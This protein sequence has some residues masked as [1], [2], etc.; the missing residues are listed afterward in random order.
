VCLTLRLGILS[1]TRNP[2]QSG[3]PCLWS[4]PCR[5]RSFAQQYQFDRSVDRRRPKTSQWQLPFFIAGR[6]GRA[7][8]SPVRW[9]EGPAYSAIVEGP[10]P[11]SHMPGS[12]SSRRR[13]LK[14]FYPFASAQSELDTGSV[15]DGQRKLPS[16]DGTHVTRLLRPLRQYHWTFRIRPAS[17]I[18]EASAVR[19]SRH[20]HVRPQF[21]GPC[22]PPQ[23]FVRES[24]VGRSYCPTGTA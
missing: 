11:W 12:P 10:A 23:Q 14:P 20:V 15:N 21:V 8:K 13:A 9:H 3:I 1:Q 17:N 19:R 2:S 5:V 18:V 7:R 22:K 16:F 6:S 4:F 24:K